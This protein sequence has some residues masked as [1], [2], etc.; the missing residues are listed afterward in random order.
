MASSDMREIL[1]MVTLGVPRWDRVMSRLTS[2]DFSRVGVHLAIFVEP[3]LQFVLEGKKTVESRFSINRVAPYRQI[4]EGDIILLKKAGGPIIG[5]CE[6]ASAWFYKLDAEAFSEIINRFGR[7][8][9]PTDD[10]FWEDRRQAGYATLISLRKVEKIDPFVLPKRDRRGWVVLKPA[11]PQMEMVMRPIVIGISG[12]IASGKT[13]FGTRLSEYLGCSIGSFGQVVREVARQRRLGMDR[14]ILQR[15]GQDLADGD[16]AKFCRDV[17]AAA[18]WK[19]GESA[20]IEGFRHVSIVEAMRQIVYPAEFKLLFL[21]VDLSTELARTGLPRSTMQLYQ[22]DRTESQL[23]QLR[24]LADSRLDG[25]NS[26]EENLLRV[27]KVF[28]LRNDD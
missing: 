3:Y 25:S 18:G 16:P 13:T 14:S 1:T 21:D 2:K 27:R 5:I 9:C 26:M 12:P 23:S 6:A 4:V 22:S 8:I 17:L 24:Q 10:Q 20:V 28:G 11:R 19:P 15:I 7:A